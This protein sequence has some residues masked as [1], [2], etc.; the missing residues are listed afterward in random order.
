MNATTP[1]VTNARLLIVDDEPAHMTALYHTLEDADY[2]VTAFSD[3]ALALESMQR[4]MFDL[5]L[6]DLK[7]PVMDGITLLRAAQKIDPHL[8]GIVM[9]GHGA[10][11]TAIEAMKAGAQDYILKPFKLSVILPVLSR[12]LEVRRMRIEIA[13]LQQRLRQHVIELEAANQELEAFSSS[14]SHDLRAPLRAIAGFSSLLVENYCAQLPADARQLLDRVQVSV[15]RMQQLIEHMLRFARL[16]RQ[17]LTRAPVDIKVLVSEVLEELRGEYQDRQVE[18]RVE[19]LPDAIGD[20]VL[21]RQV[22]I[23]LLSN[24]FKFTRQRARAVIEIGSEPTDGTL[25]YFVRDNGA[26]FDMRYT[27]RLFSAFYRLHDASTFEGVGIGLSLVQR[28]IQ[29]HGGRIWTKA[30]VDQGATF[31]FTLPE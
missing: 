5:L 20:S 30:A 27:E 26:G 3:A 17:S 24:A 25:V 4:Q 2:D 10:I 22:F 9:T 15:N 1:T 11:D 21:L 28:I 19:S 14:I 16:S 23:N 8:V 29:R 12:A 6:T 18:I 13:D 7:M 31:F